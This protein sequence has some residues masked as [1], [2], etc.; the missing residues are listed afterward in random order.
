MA[1]EFRLPLVPV[2]PEAKE[3]VRKQLAHM[4][5]LPKVAA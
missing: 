1:E 4:G 5:L 2:T 3:M